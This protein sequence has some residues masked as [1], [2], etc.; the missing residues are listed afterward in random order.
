MAKPFRIEY[1][2]PFYHVMNQGN[3]GEDLFISKRDR[4]KFLRCLEKATERFPI[5]IHTYCLM[6]NHCHP[7]LETPEANLSISDFFSIS[8]AGIAMRYKSTSVRIN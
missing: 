6:T 2:G 4:E 8:C 5:L 3:A 1:P 7:L